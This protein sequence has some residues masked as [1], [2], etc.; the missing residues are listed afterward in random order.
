MMELQCGRCNLEFD[1]LF[2]ECPHCNAPSIFA[3]PLGQVLYDAEI[4]DSITDIYDHS[5]FAELSADSN[6]TSHLE[7]ND[8]NMESDGEINDEEID[9]DAIDDLIDDADDH[10]DLLES[11]ED[12]IDLDDANEIQDGI[13]PNDDA[14]EIHGG[15]EADDVLDSIDN[16]DWMD[17]DFEGNDDY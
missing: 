6:P 17:S 3:T 13:D 5:N 15:I 12:Q 11:L 10:E 7:P 2:L 4:V 8:A 14:N 1:S 9:D 16:D